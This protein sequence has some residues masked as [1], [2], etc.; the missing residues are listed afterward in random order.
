MARFANTLQPGHWR[1]CTP[2][3]EKNL[4]GIEHKRT[5]WKLGCCCNENNEDFQRPLFFL[6]GFDGKGRVVDKRW[7]HQ[8][9]VQ[10]TVPNKRLLINT[11]ICLQLK[12]SLQ[13]DL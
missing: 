6:H 2:R 3:E 8:T 1:F 13:C 7:R 5:Q 11:S 12:V 9:H 10:C 4:L